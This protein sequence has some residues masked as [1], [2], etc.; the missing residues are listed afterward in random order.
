MENTNYLKLPL[1]IPNQ[2][3]KEITHNEALVF[4][5]NILQNGAIDRHLQIPPA[6]PNANDLYIVANG[7]GGDWEGKDNQIAFYDNGWKYL[8]PREGA[9]LWVNDEDCLYSFNGSV[10]VQS[11]SGS[12]SGENPGGEGGATCLNELS[13][14]A[15]SSIAKYNILQHDGEKFTNTSNI[16]GISMLGVNATA[17]ETNKLSVKSEV[18]LFDNIGSGAQVKV[19]KAASTDVATHLFQTAYSGRAEFGLAGNDNFT[20]KVS[21]DGNDWYESFVV[22]SSTGN[23]DFKGIITNNGGA[24]GSGSGGTGGEY[25]PIPKSNDGVIG[26]I[27]TIRQVGGTLVA[28]NGGTW[29]YFYIN[30]NS[31][32]TI[33]FDSANLNTNNNNP[34]AGI[35][36]GGTTLSTSTPLPAKYSGF[37][38]RIA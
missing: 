7:A 10:W 3:G 17:D 4:I 8:D 24:I 29:F 16:Q 35:C 36:A 13:D 22:D 19:N 2:S 37:F 31:E 38:W 6:S 1:L 12:S 25:M 9:T 33:Y 34:T 20:L 30:L 18:I 5:D 32:N 28:P 15:I 26:Q 23:I 27:V 11:S 14:V 21:P